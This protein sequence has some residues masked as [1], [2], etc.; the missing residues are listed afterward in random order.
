MEQKTMDR[1]T[2]RGI[3]RNF[4]PHP[5][6]GDELDEET[7]LY[8]DTIAARTGNPAK[9]PID[10]IF[11]ACTGDGANFVHLL[12]GHRGCGKSTELNK[13]E[14]RFIEEGFAVKKID[15][16][17]EANIAN[18][19]V[20]DV[21]ILISNALL[22]ICNDKGI[23]INPS[24]IEILD[25]FFASIDKEVK[26][27]EEKTIEMSAGIGAKFAYIIKLVARQKVNL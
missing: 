10:D 18:M 17:T 16:K 5:L 20:E 7:G 1:T 3:R 23:N 27:G 13:L 15:C 26:I 8:V 9:S 25:S 22:S 19:N 14:R 21:L 12:L 6:K 2:I 11:E 4:F 24:D